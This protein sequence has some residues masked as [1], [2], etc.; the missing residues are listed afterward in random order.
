MITNA[1]ALAAPIDR[2]RDVDADAD[3]HAD[4]PPPGP[5]AHGDPPEVVIRPRPGWIAVDWAEMWAHR[6]LFFFLIWR[7]IS[8]RYKQTALGPAW[9]VVQPMM[10]MAIFTMI[11][12]RFAGIPPEGFPYPVFVFA[13]LMPWTLFSQGLSASALSLVN[14]QQMLTKVYFP[15]LFVPLASACV[16]LVDMAISAGLYGLIL[17]YYGVAPSWQSAWLAA[18]VP[19]TLVATLGLGLTL[20]S[21][22]VF[23]R[24]FKHLVPFLVQI[25]MYVSAVFFPARMVGRWWPLLSLNPMFGIIDAYRSAILSLPWHLGS[26][27]I[28]TAVAVL[29]FAFSL[30]YFRKTERQFADFA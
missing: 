26:L 29:L 17:L 15:R 27:A 7:D 24:D 9:A 21:L 16:Y 19:L 1:E 20:A 14:S 11:F 8:V 23:Y 10:T 30:F 25:L 2:R 13:G 4:E 3:M 6:E 28:S 22:T 18:L 5:A 12:G